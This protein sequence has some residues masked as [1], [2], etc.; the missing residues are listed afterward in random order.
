[1]D[2]SRMNQ[3]GWQGR[4]FKAWSALL[5]VLLFCLPVYGQPSNDEWVNATVVTSIPFTDTVDTTSATSNPVDPSLS[6]NGNGAQT[7]G[8]TV[9]YVWTPAADIVVNI[10]TDGSTEPDGDPLDTAHGVFTGTFGNLTEVACVDIGLTDDLVFE[11]TGGVTYYIKV[12][13]FLDGVGGGNLVFTVELPPEPELLV[14]ESVHDGISRP[15]SSIVGSSS[16]RLNSALA[17]EPSL[18]DVRVKEIPRFMRGKSGAPAKAARATLGP[19]DVESFQAAKEAELLQIFDGADNDDNAFELG[20]L[21]APPDTNG[22]VGPGHYVQMVNLLTTIFDKQ[23]NVLLGPF[24]N[25]VFWSGLGGLCQ[26]TNNGDPIV[27]Y[28]EATDR[29]LVSQ[30]AFNSRFTRFSLCIAVSTTGD[31]TG[32]YFQHEFDFTGIGF[33]DYPK[34]GFVTGAIGVMVNLFEPFQG[35]GVGAIDK[36]EAFS[37]QRTTMVFFKLGPQE[38]GFLPGDND[39]PRFDD[40]PP[41]FATNNGGSG[42]RIDFWEIHPD[43]ATPANS[44]ISEVAKIPVSPIDGDLCPASRE[45]CIDQPGSGTGTP[46]NNITFLEAISDTLM[47]RLQLRDFGFNEDGERDKRA[48]VSA[49]VDANG[50]GKAGIQWYEFRNDGSGWGL[51]QEDTFSPDRDHRWM[52]SIAMNRKGETCLGYSI[53]SERTHPSIGIACRTGSS[54]IFDVREQVVFDGNVDGFVQRQTA[55]WGDY[56]AMAVDPVNDTFWYTQEHARPNSFIGER[57]GWATKIVHFKLPE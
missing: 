1:M 9:W 36:A 18:T 31:P 53:S 27:L 5:V 47:H 56:S 14:L 20:I 13:E 46:P 24:A 50:R 57:F 3:P 28:D 7:D 49:T 45:R 6:C 34:Y 51:F 35:A 32:S 22:D 30:F 40:M 52:G 15:I 23:G 12:G 44:T 55:R 26:T 11:A 17:G 19:V 48:V 33:P 43:F 29:W 4:A 41:T 38:F 2:Y 39:G 54:P 42:N 21:L 37:D 16:S 10:S 8:N 25:N